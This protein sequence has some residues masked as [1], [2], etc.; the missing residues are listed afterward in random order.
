VFESVMLARQPIFKKDNSLYGFELLYRNDA[1]NHA[2]INN[3]FAATS[4]LLVNLCT[5]ALEENLNLNLPLFINVDEE[6]ITSTSF[7]PGPSV[8]VIL[9]ILET[10]QPTAEVLQGIKNLRAKGFHFALDD[11]T[12]CPSRDAFLPFMS[13]IKV[14]LLELPLDEIERKIERFKGTRKIMLAEKVEDLA[15]YERCRAMGF[16]LFQGYFLERPKIVKGNKVLAN[17]QVLVKLIAQLCQPDISINEVSEII[18]CDPRFIFKILKIVNCPLYPFR[19][20]VENIRQAVIMLGLEAI[21]KWALVL[22]MMS[23]TNAPKELFRML[24]TRAKTC[25][26]FALSYYKDQSPDYFT[27]GLFSG[28]D[29]VLETNLEDILKDINLSDSLSQELLFSTGNYHGVLADVRSYQL[30]IQSEVQSFHN[31][32]F[33]TMSSCFTQGMR[34][35]DELMYLL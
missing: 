28:M 10:V 34:W 24:L 14:D 13:I 31:D 1:V 16:N 9:E 32:K 21:K 3:A 12:F 33:Q 35:A 30:N 7:F 20:E 17:K 18:S 4:E 19:R 27:L 29:A 8:N 23:D 22:V 2:T 26:L 15:S 25:E 11:Y 5:N 6:F